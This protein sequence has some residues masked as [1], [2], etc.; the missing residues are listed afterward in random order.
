MSNNEDTSGAG[1]RPQAEPAPVQ[2]LGLPRDRM[3]RTDRSY[4]YGD[5]LFETIR[6]QPDGSVRWLDRHIARLRRS[7]DAL[8]YPADHLEKAVNTLESLPDKKPGIWRVTVPRAPEGAPFGGSATMTCRHRPYSKPA[9][10]TLGLAEGL[11]LPD[12]TLAQHKTTSFVRYI[13]A[14]R[15][16][17]RAGFDDAL[18][19]SASG[20]VGEASCANIVAVIDGQAVTPPLRGILPGVTRAGILELAE[21][22][23]QPIEVHELS[24]DELRRADEVALLSSGVGVLAA[25]SL[26]GRP[27]SEDWTLVAQEWLS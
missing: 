1:A 5:A 19:V 4:L 17:E 14:R 22:N 20:L 16:A 9:R 3:L 23:G 8:G 21:T 27:L 11:Y 13:E 7:G 18:L 2:P 25:A 6:V 24:V 10:P 26:E 12:D 15:R